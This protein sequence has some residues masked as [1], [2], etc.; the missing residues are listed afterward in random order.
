M[1]QSWSTVLNKEW[2]TRGAT[3]WLVMDPNEFARSDG[4]MESGSKV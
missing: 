2:P 4:V 1:K 3:G